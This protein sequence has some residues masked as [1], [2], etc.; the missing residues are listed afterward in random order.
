MKTI[1]SIR[2]GIS[3]D[4]LYYDFKT[5]EMWNEKN[6]GKHRDICDYCFEMKIPLLYNGMLFNATGEPD[7]EQYSIS[8]FSN[9]QGRILLEYMND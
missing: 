5:G 7:A 8:D 2:S 1:I 3:D 6:R 4:E 9:S